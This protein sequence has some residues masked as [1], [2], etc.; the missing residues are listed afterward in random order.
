[1]IPPTRWLPMPVLSLLLLLVWLLLQHS[2]SPGQWI[3]G[4]VLAIVIPLVA[5]PFW[6]RQPTIKR[7]LKLI[8]YVLRVL[9]DI[10]VAN[11]Q[12]SRLILDP[13]GRMRPAFVEYPLTLKENF[14]ITVL[15]STI[16]MTPGTVSAHLR[17]DGK[18]LLIHA[19]DVGDIQALIDE[20]HE[21]YERPLMEIFES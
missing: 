15:A 8:H 17:L 6:E 14:S 18:T 5:R 1:M 19:L 2:I 20:I 7:P 9:K 12:V 16:T 21:R 11:L 3:L 13:R 4:G 10:V